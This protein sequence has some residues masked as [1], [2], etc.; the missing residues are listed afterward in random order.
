MRGRDRNGTA[1]TRSLH[2]PMC[3]KMTRGSWVDWFAGSLRHLTYARP[4][5]GGWL[6]PIAAAPLEH[7][8]VCEGPE[9]HE[10]GD[11]RDDAAVVVHDHRGKSPK[12]VRDEGD[13]GDAQD[14]EESD[15]EDP[16]R[17]RLEP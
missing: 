10:E 6:L 17:D 3:P 7:D 16:K 11:G 1:L 4:L 2:A 8:V 9:R 5:I 14:V 15:P 13:R 12:E